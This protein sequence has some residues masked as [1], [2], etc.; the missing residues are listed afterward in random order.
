MNKSV[1]ANKAN[2]TREQYQ[3]QRKQERKAQSLAT[4]AI[5]Q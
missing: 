1:T 5:V 4:R 2:L 3:E